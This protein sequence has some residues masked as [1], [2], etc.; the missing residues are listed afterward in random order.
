MSQLQ[1]NLMT[2]RHYIQVIMT[3]I[4][5]CELPICSLVCNLSTYI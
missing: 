1:N 4:S 5:E 2:L 3:P